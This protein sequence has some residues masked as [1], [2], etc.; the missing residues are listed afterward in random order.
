M[1]YYILFFLFCL[2]NCLFAQTISFE[3][4]F[5]LKKGTIKH[6]YVSH[7]AKTG[8]IKDKDDTSICQSLVIKGR[9]IFYFEEGCNSDDTVITGSQSFCA[10]AFYYSKS[11]AFYFSPLFW[12][13]EIK[14]ANL[15]YFEPL[16]PAKISLNTPYKYQDGEEKKKYLFKKFEDVIIG[17]RTYR[18][19]LKLIVI[20][21]WPTERYTDTVW[22]QNG[23]G[24]VKWLRSTG[25]L[26]ELRQ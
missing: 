19:C 20:H 5:P 3:R 18:H 16:F 11:G 26:E 12:K 24:V 2:S 13:Y 25:R 6:Y 4:Y 1:R 14:K 17:K 21:N 7:I 8:T 10:G 23:L 9:E 15:N 22:F